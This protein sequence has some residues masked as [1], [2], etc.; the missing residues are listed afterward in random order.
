MAERSKLVR[1]R[2][3]FGVALVLALFGAAF[4]VWSVT[5][6]QNAR[7][8]LADAR[9]QLRADRANASIAGKRLRY[10]Q[11]VVQTIHDQLAGLDAH[12]GNLADQDQK[13]LDAVRAAVQAGLGGVLADYNAAVD[14]R[15]TLD[16]QHDTTV[17]QLREEANAVI[18][19]LDPLR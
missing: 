8:D 17:E 1:R 7:D 12:V 13:D 16:A 19:A 2:V 3:A 9:V 18:S 11:D 6:H 4:L 5:Q 10:T 15:T 14:T